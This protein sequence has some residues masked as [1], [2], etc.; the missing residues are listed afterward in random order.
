ML[1]V[2]H[3]THR[4]FTLVELIASL[5]VG[6]VV[7]GSFAIVVAQ[8]ERVHARLGHRIRARSQA[9]EGLAALMGELRALSPAAGDI[10]PG[11]ARDSAVEFRATV[12]TLTVCTTRDRVLVSA[13]ASFVTPPEPGDTAWAYTAS[14]SGAGWRPLAIT[15]VSA[16]PADEPVACATPVAV[17]GVDK[18]RRANARV[19]L[20]LSEPPPDTLL[21]GTAVRVT[22][23][24]RYSL[25]RAPD[26]RWYLGRREWSAARSRFETIQPVGGPYRPYS[27]AGS[28]GLELRYFDRTGAEVPSGASETDRIAKITA[29][30]R[31]L[32]PP[33]DSGVQERRDVTSIT[34]ALR[35]PL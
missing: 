35:N 11:A 8:Q 17:L 10:P 12:G 1:T 34:V 31:A 6:G 20:G 21:D 7:F 33:T 32:P 5:V 22:R 24:L 29:T 26:G 18:P 27:F 30:L 9:V 28:S 2:P 15:E 14:D 19:A 3:A 23:R 25:Y 4:G 16:M 13:F